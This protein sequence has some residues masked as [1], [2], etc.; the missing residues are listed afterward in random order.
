[1]P[2]A[3]FISLDEYL[4]TSYRPDCDFI[5]G[6]VQE[7]NLGERNHSTLQL[8]LGFVFKQNRYVWN[9]VPLVEQRVQ[10]S[11][12]RYRVPDL[13]VV[14]KDDPPDQIVHTPPLIC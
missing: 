1:M 12:T 7:R 3:L 13:C 10:V 8:A 5:D 9:V 11:E 2:Q 14:R 4:R 6:E